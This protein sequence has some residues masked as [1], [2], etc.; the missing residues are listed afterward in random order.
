MKNDVTL[1]SVL[2]YEVVVERKTLC[3][4]VGDYLCISWYCVTGGNSNYVSRGIV[5]LVVTVIMYLVAL[6][7][8]W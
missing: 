1:H 4:I 2:K 6:C 3:G 8:W 7:Y 5:L